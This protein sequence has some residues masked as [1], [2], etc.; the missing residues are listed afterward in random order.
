[1][2]KEQIITIAN[3]YGDAFYVFDLNAFNNNYFH[4]LNSFKKHYS[5]VN[6][7][8]SY[9]TNYIPPICKAVQKNGGYAEIVSD[10]ELDI[11]LHCGVPY[12]R[13]IWNGP[14]KDIERAVEVSN[15]GTIINIDNII[16][17]KQLLSHS[18][19]KDNLNVG[20]RI[21][22]D[23][24][25]GVV[26]RFGFDVG[27]DDY[28]QTLETIA[29]S[30][31]ICLKSVHCHFAKRSLKYWPARVDGAIKEFKNII[32]K[33]NLN[34]KIL[35]LGG[36]I[37]GNMPDVLKEQFVDSIPTYE[38]YASIIGPC[39]ANA[40][41]N[42]DIEVLTEPGTALA[43]DVVCFVAK[44]GNIK[45]IRNKTF[46]TLLGSQKNI[47]IVGKNPPI[48]IIN[49]SNETENV[50]DADFVGYTCIEGDVL[51][52]NFSG[53]IGV[54]DFIV[55][56]NCGSYSIV[57]KPPFILPNFPVLQIEGKTIILVKRK[58]TFEDLFSTYVF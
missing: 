38:D 52:K 47:N 2:N 22:F 29:K 54:G 42:A 49:V 36:G 20:I 16:E 24:G 28:K 41:P 18:K 35:D 45:K 26:S 55:F 57:M 33:Y 25:D 19:A 27:G 37:Y 12:N 1:M 34:P 31:N 53:E 56:S 40:F 9:K 43:A 39:I 48:E 30:Q 58:E 13:I 32:K 50:I 11:A 3:K 51:Y 15:K 8:Y 4:F 14:V 10:M 5:N 7:A 46:V 6:V 21:N 44:V 23:V 17:L